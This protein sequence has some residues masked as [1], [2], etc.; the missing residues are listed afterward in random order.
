MTDVLY[1]AFSLPRFR[2]RGFDSVFNDIVCGVEDLAKSATEAIVALSVAVGWAAG[3]LFKAWS[4]RPPNLPGWDKIPLKKLLGERF[5]F[6]STLNTM[7]M[8]ALWRNGISVRAGDQEHGIS[9]HGNGFWCRTDTGC[10][11]LSGSL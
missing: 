4:S 5:A 6:P 1:A 11:A 10:S 3:C 2:Q 7:A 8:P 9:D